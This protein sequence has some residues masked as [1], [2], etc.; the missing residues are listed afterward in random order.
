MKGEEIREV[1]EGMLES[2]GFDPILYVIKQY[3]DRCVVHFDDE[4]A[5]DYLMADVEKYSDSAQN[6]IMYTG[7]EGKRHVLTFQLW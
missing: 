1:I 6:F 7:R 2:A 4:G 3:G 5:V